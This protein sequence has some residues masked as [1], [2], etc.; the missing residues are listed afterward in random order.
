[1]P[2]KIKSTP[3][4]TPA[5]ASVHTPVTV[6]VAVALS[7]IDEDRHQPRSESN[8]GFSSSSLAELAASIRLRGVK[9]PISVRDDLARPG[10]FL[11][12]H[13][14][15]RYRAS[16]LA[17]KTDIPAFVDNDYN[18]A[19]QVVENLQRNALTA[20]EIADYIGRELAKGCKRVDIAAS[21][22]K[23]P[24]FVTQHAT[25]LDLPDS[26]AAAM[27][28][29]RVNDV[30]IIND[31]VSMHR[32]WPDEV[33]AWLSTQGQELTRGTLRMLR[34]LLSERDSM[35]AVDQHLDMDIDTDVHGGAGMD[36]GDETNALAP[37]GRIARP[38]LHVLH[39]GRSARLLLQRRPSRMGW[40]WIMLIDDDVEQEVALDELI[41][42][43]LLDA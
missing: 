5:A 1:M 21:I 20:R 16:R 34:A 43:A 8:P 27:S 37:A 26:V 7:A 39:A 17:G 12:N 15:R 19:D 29:G 24:A 10:R 31:L 23:S 4:P 41:L 2:R 6:P 35:A 3:F 42:V 30:T 11:I 14:A 22:S 33:A 25:L 32:R 13:G 28:S 36:G 38:A 18:A 9:T 40:A